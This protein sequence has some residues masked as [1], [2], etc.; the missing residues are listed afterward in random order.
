MLFLRGLTDIGPFP[1]SVIIRKKFLAYH[2]V[3]D[4]LSLSC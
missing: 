4:I 2:S 1:E 3:S